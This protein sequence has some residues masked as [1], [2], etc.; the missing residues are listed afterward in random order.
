[1]TTQRTEVS[2]GQTQEEPGPE[3]THSAQS[4]LVSPTPAANSS[5][6]TLSPQETAAPPNNPQSL[7]R[8]LAPT[9]TTGCAPV[10]RPRI[11]WPQ[12]S[13]RS[14][15]QQFDED[16]DQA[17]E[18][19]AKGD[20]DRRLKTMTSFIVNIAAERF[21]TEAPKATPSA[22]AP[23]HR[24]RKIQSLRKELKLLKRQ[25]KTAGEIERAGLADLRAILRKQLLTL[26]RAEF[27]R[28]RRK[29][30]ARKRTAF[31]ANPFKLTKQLLGQKRTGRLTCSKDVI[32]N[33]LK[34]DRKS[35]V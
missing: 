29:E 34:A 17:L 35:V 12:S 4:L 10:A 33:H 25:Y 19:T 28:R 7:Q 30:R 32:N 24:A 15:W 16:I 2:S 21:G 18:V 26:R 1:M 22:Y 14:E 6:A 13:K 8:Q 11:Q 27:H 20:V 3:A 9:I 23:N 5:H 31:L